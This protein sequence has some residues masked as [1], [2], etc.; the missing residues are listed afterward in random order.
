MKKLLIMFFA[1]AF[2]GLNQ[3]TA[4]DTPVKTAEA[5]EKAAMKLV[6]K[7]MKDEVAVADLPEA[8]HTALEADDYK[9][10]TISKAYKVKKDD[11]KFYKLYLTQG[12]EEVKVKML[13]N[14]ELYRKSE[15]K[16]ENQ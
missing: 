16:L 9:G 4:Q 7:E 1:V 11:A 14:G 15:S 5:K 3:A 12:D 8:V 2:F 10:W 13:P 6:D